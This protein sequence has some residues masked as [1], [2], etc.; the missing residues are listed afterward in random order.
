MAEFVQFDTTELTKI[1]DQLEERA[2]K[3]GPEVMPA[4]AEVLVSAVQDEFESQGDGKWPPLAESTLAKRRRDGRG[5]KILE[6]TGIFAGSITPLTGPE[7]AEAYTNVP[8]AVYHTSDAPRTKI[9][10][11]NPFQI[12]EEAALDQMAE[13]VLKAAV[14]S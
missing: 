5:A 6:D 4:M 3:I 7:F 12:D 1:F 13:M 14:P 8:Y 11:R 2:E 9:P 10:Y